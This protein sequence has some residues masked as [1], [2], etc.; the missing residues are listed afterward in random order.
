MV[1]KWFGGEKVYVTTP[2]FQVME[3]LSEAEIAGLELAIEKLQ[4]VNA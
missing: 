3:A 4:E 2:N 1:R